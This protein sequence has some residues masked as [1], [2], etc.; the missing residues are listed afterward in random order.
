MSNDD[1]EVL[2]VNNELI[3]N[4]KLNGF[5]IKKNTFLM[6]IKDAPGNIYNLCILAVAAISE[7]V[8][9]ILAKVPGIGYLVDL[10]AAYAKNYAS[11]VVSDEFFDNVICPL[12]GLE[13]NFASPEYCSAYV[14][15]TH[16]E[17]EYFQISMLLKSIATFAMEHPGLVLAGGALLVGLVIKLFIG[18]CKKISN[19]INYNSM[20][21]KQKD[22]YKE[23]KKVLKNSRKIKKTENGKILLTDLNATYQIIENIQDY[24]DML[25]KISELLT[26]LNKAIQ[27]KDRKSYETIRNELE[28]HVFNFE[29]E[30]N[31]LLNKKMRLIFIK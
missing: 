11:Q 15:F 7:Y 4:E 26:R 20:S 16:H 12:I 25:N 31:N 8:P 18:I 22:V 6:F 9:E 10:I 3:R 13:V 17:G 2:T 27:N 5:D 28:T 30:N 21:D 1:I 14:Q 24:P 29:K 23:L 19:S